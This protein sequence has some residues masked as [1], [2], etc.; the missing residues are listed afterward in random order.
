MVSDQ[1]QRRSELPSLHIIV[2]HVVLPV[3]IGSYVYVAYRDS[4][5]L[6]FTWANMANLGEFVDIV[7]HYK[8]CRYPVENFALYC[9]P[10]GLWVYSFTAC[11]LLI[12]KQKISKENISWILLPMFLGIGSE[13]GQ[14]LKVVPGTFDAW[15][16]S[17]YIIF[18]VAAIY[19][20]TK[21]DQNENILN[22]CV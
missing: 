4:Q 15:D 6:L 18:G 7:R 10:N 19:L 14:L 9:A 2:I 13:C 16:L 17:A 21:N 3:A 5:L 12:W 11:L 20:L 8:L 1:V 22:A